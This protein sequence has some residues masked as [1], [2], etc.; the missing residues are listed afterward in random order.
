MSKKKRPDR[1]K[2]A[3]LKAGRPIPLA[4]W[5]LSFS[6]PKRSRTKIRRRELAVD[7]GVFSRAPS[8]GNTL[9]QAI[10]D[11][12]AY[13]K[14]YE[15]DRRDYAM[16]ERL[17]AL[18]KGELEALK[19][20]NLRE[21]IEQ[22]D[23][24]DHVKDAIARMD[25]T[26]W[27]AVEILCTRYPVEADEGEAPSSYEPSKRRIRFAG[28]GRAL[29]YKIAGVI[30]VGD[31]EDLTVKDLSGPLSQ[32]D[33]KRAMGHELKKRAWPLWGNP[34]SN[35]TLPSGRKF[36]G[37]GDFYAWKNSK[38][39]GGR[40]KGRGGGGLTREERQRAASADAKARA[41]ADLTA[42]R[43]EELRKAGRNADADRLERRSRLKRGPKQVST[44]KGSGVFARAKVKPRKNRSTRRKK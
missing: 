29:L 6:P 32:A 43:V 39:K 30:E 7:A 21:R 22:S 9:A 40:P 5:R 2:R 19:I 23:A 13:L 41:R 10:S 38:S 37:K 25:M 12:P 42:K 18:P 17:R 3:W 24:P 33:L 8:S 1:A 31:V 20:A 34:P 27:Y 15:E 36:M 44:T 16:R 4:E 26:R 35:V 28:I 14:R 11:T